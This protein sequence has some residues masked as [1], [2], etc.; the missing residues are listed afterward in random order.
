M[1]SV[2]W[3]VGL[4]YSGSTTNNLYLSFISKVSLIGL[5]LGVVALT[6][7]VSVM[8][9]FDREL[10]YRILGASPHVV[11]ASPQ[12]TGFAP[13]LRRN[14]VVM[15]GGSDRLVSVFG[16]EPDNEPSIIG[17][18]VR[19]GEISDLVSAANRIMMGRPLG[20]QLGVNVG[21]TLTIV[22]PEPSASGSTVI[23]KM[24][25]VSVSGF[26]ELDSELDYGLILMNRE[27]L[28][29]ALGAEEKV[30]RIQLDNIFV[31]ASVADSLKSLTGTVR[32]QSWADEYGDFFETVRM[33][34]VMMFVLLTMVVAIAAFNI[35]SG[36]SM[37]VKEKKM[38]IAVFRTL[39]LTQWQVMQIFVVQGAV[40]GLLG[41]LI[42]LVIGIPV[43]MWVGDIIRVFEDM[44]GGRMLAGTYFDQVPSDVR[45]ADI[46]VIGVVSLAI[47]LVASLYPAYRA[48]RLQPAEVLRYE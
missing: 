44:L 37:M 3:F 21:D 34:K 28:A 38:D 36:L 48:A 9:G 19:Q 1:N 45:F 31:A 16:I 7:V 46:V 43:A 23:P 6:V 17:E 40:V 14:G 42:G 20:Y 33:E 35:V 8:N 5:V 27:D 30:F 22:V 29:R 10:K 25:R 11:D 32:V 24:M 47:S 12:V 15:T 41:V 18:H 39:G 4:R 2:P 13:F 26:F